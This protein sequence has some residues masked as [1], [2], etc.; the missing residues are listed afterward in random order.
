MLKTYNVVTL[1]A[2]VATLL[3]GGVLEAQTTIGGDVKPK[4]ALRLTISGDLSLSFVDRSSSFGDAALG[5]GSG[6]AGSPLAA[7]WAEPVR[8]GFFIDPIFQIELD[9]EVSEGVNALI[10]LETPFDASENLRDGQLPLGVDEA[11]ISWKG[12][13]NPDLNLEMGLVHYDLDLAGNGHPMFLSLGNSESA[14]DNPN[15]G[16]DVGTPQSSSA[17]LVDSLNPSG[18]VGY[19]D[20]GENSVDVLMFDLSSLND[21]SL[22]GFVYN[23]PLDAGD[24]SGEM[25]FTFINTKNDG[26]SD[27][28]TFG[29]GAN[30]SGEDGLKFYGELYLQT[31]DYGSGVGAGTIDQDAHAFLAGVRYDI[32]EIDDDSAPWIDVS[33]WDYSGDSDSADGKNGNFVSYEFN[34]DTVV[35]ED[36]YYGLDLDTNYRA[37]KFK[38]GMNLS[39]EW[40]IQAMYAYAYLNSNSGGFGSN[41]SNNSDKLGDEFDIRA[42]YRATDFLTF[43]LNAGTLQ[44]AKALG[45]GSGVEVMTLTSEVRF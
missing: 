25:G 45:V 33:I 22:F 15:A 26:G 14:F 32:P 23:M 24:Y 19:Y 44:N 17:G 4:R 39:P 5:N 38:G 31:G 16:F 9:A 12:A 30:V 10:S 43:H 37:F 28:F 11:K 13:M 2:F 29:G 41:P 40:S 27:L 3:V 35:L 34:N 21:E 6:G 42:T 7:N 1:I 20:L 18:V 36:A 8:D